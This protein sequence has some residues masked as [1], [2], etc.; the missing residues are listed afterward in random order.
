MRLWRL[1]QHLQLQV[2]TVAIDQCS[3][4]ESY[5]LS[6]CSFGA[7]DVA[8]IIGD[9]N[10]YRAPNVRGSP[11]K[12]EIIMNF[13]DDFTEENANEGYFNYTDSG[14]YAYLVRYIFLV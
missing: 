10:S 11:D 13:G 3:T 5:G 6:Y 12:I 14:T 2:C 7:K 9:I 1:S 4:S 8:S